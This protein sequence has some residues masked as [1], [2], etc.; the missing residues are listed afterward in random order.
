MVVVKETDAKPVYGWVRTEDEMFSPRGLYLDEPDIQSE[1]AIVVKT[2]AGNF[3][4]EEV[5]PRE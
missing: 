4:I 2:V 5:S 3:K 1:E